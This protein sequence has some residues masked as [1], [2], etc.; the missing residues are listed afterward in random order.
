MQA[1]I[2]TG[3]LTRA[4]LRDGRIVDIIPRH[5]RAVTPD[6]Q[7]D[8]G[9]GS[10]RAGEGVS[11]LRGIVP[12]ATD[13]AVVSRD[14]A[15]RHEQQRGA[16][17]GDGVNGGGHE[18]GRADG[19]SGAGELP[20]AVGRVD[21]HVRDGARVLAR[22]DEAEVVAARLA[23]HQVGREERSGQGGDGVGEEGLL[24]VRRHRVDLVEGEPEEAV[25]VVLYE[26]GTDGIGQ[27]DGLPR[28]Y[29]G[30]DAD[31]V[32]VDVAA[33]P[34]AVAVRDVPGLA[35]EDLGGAGQ[36]W[37]VER[38]AEVIGGRELGGED[39]AMIY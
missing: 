36:G 34:A 22:V 14:N 12:R 8:T 32:G 39:P 37:I 20:E 35:A 18:V 25:V 27:L 1:G 24:L 26:L 31:D 33:R 7:R 10:S 17:V 6:A 9:Q 29:C 13:L 11:A 30:A 5:H 16:R 15:L 2:S 28:H 38:V 19:V 21:G 23:F 4:A 3:V